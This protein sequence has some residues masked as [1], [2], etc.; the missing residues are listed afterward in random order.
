MRQ[1][2]SEPLIDQKY[3]IYDNERDL[4]EKEESTFRS[5]SVT[6]HISIACD[7]CDRNSISSIPNDKI[8]REEHRTEA[9]DPPDGGYGWVICAACFMGRFSK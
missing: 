8:L 6:N 3:N 1:I 9:I 5:T 2:S 4:K 7:K